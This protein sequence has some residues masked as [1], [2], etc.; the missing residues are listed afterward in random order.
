MTDTHVR[1]PTDQR[2]RLLEALRSNHERGAAL[3]MDP[4]TTGFL[5]TDD[6]LPSEQVF[7]A[8]K[9]IPNHY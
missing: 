1:L 3:V 4:K 8:V 6:E 5:G 2:E 7:T 9:S